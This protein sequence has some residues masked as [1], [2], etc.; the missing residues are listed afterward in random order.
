M[1]S[2]NKL[3]MILHREWVHKVDASQYFIKFNVGLGDTNIC[4]PG[5]VLNG[6]NLLT[7]SFS[8]S[9]PNGDAKFNYCW[10]SHTD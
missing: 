3:Q 10:R 9:V 5:S 8:R 6:D 4:F 2:K 1:Q 7:F